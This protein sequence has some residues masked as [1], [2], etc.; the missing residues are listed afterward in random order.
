MTS[1][2][3]GASTATYAH[4]YGDRLYS[5]TSNFPNEGN[6]TYDYGGDDKRR[7]R[8]T[9]T[10]YSWYNYDKGFKLL[11]EEDNT[12]T[13]TTTHTHANPNPIV[14]PTLADVP[15]TS[16]AAGTYRNYLHDRLGSSIEMRDQS[17][18][19]LSSYEYDPYGSVY[20][21]AGSPT[22]VMF[23]GHQRDE[24]SGLY[25]APYR[26]YSPALARWVS[27]DLLGMADGTNIFGYVSGRPIDFY[28]PL[29]MYGLLHTPGD[30]TDPFREGRLCKCKRFSP[31]LHEL[32]GMTVR[33]CAWHYIRQML[34]PPEVPVLAGA[35]AV[36][37][38]SA[39]FVYTGLTT[40]ATFFGFTVGM[41]ANIIIPTSA[42]G[43]C[44]V[45]KCLEYE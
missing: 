31:R 1:K 3:D 30:P 34:T 40:F 43:Y 10:E 38:R 19:L 35:S 23:T 7:E 8:S 26:Y 16:P 45:R 29:G 22:S 25:Y 14:S 4:R 5:V 2:T 41:Y 17:K 44:L 39:A 15:S 20:A 9:A 42:V 13:L 11:N 24:A 32:M 36:V 27:R 33:Q 18:V 6:V 28:D 37:L 12:G 21:A